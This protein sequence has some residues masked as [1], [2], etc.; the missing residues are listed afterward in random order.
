MYSIKI[1]RRAVKDLKKVSKEYARLIGQHIDQL[2]ENPRPQDA[3]RLKGTT[4]YSLRIGVNRI[5]YDINDEEKVVTIYRI[6]HR[7]EAYR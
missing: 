4:D 7:S 6:K 2:K 1:L 3:K 5:V